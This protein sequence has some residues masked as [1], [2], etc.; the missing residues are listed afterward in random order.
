MLSDI[1][2]YNEMGAVRAEVVL[3]GY[4]LIQIETR[5]HHLTVDP[6]TREVLLIYQCWFSGD[7]LLDC[8]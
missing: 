7:F 8:S 5:D 3:A 6:I 1:Q 4:Q 2:C